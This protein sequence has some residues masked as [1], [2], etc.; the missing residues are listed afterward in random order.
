MRSR[1]VERVVVV[2]AQD[3]IL[4]MRVRGGRAS[5]AG[6]A[7]K[8]RRESKSDSEP[9]GP[10]QRGRGREDD[11]EDETPGRGHGARVRRVRGHGQRR[12]GPRRRRLRRIPGQP[13]LVRQ[14]RRRRLLLQRYVLRVQTHRTGPGDVRGR[15]RRRL[16]VSRRGPREL[17]A[18]RRARRPGGELLRQ[19]HE[20]QLGLDR[21]GRPRVGAPVHELRRRVPR[22]RLPRLRPAA[23]RRGG[24][25][26]L[27]HDRRHRL[28]RVHL[29]RRQGLRPLRD[30]RLRDAQARPAGLRPRA[31]GPVPRP[32]RQGR[33]RLL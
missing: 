2:R 8:R 3:E 25:R 17:D 5:V 23:G 30:H 33:R 12:D 24:R 22:P 15:R 7:G 19:E 26:G 18:H 29:A 21:E 9:S 32:P 6:A 11:D 14:L 16:R 27:R 1:A 13:K 10:G 31:A 28:G 20:R 4:G